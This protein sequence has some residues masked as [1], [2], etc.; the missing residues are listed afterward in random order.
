MTTIAIVEDDEYIGDL[1]AEALTEEGYAVIR[2]YSG[3]EALMLLE[4]R[5]PDLILMDLMLPGLSGEAL[6]PCCK[7]IPVIVVSAKA[8]VDDKVKL[9]LDGAADYVTKP[10][11]IRELLARI[12]VCL[13]DAHEPDTSLLWAKGLCLNTV[14]REVLAENTPVHLTRTEFA[15][16]KTLMQTPTQVISKSAILDRI[17]L[18]TPD[19]AES[20]LK[21]HISNLRK[22]LNAVG[23]KEYIESVW[24]IGFK[25]I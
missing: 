8:D 10:F 17:S 11:Q 19:C 20:S 13:R 9:L 4:H 3:T 6:L 23:G 22:K 12:T 2:A 25:L 5:H 21:V 24:G 18:E 15:I 16:L 14:T 1:L 7:G